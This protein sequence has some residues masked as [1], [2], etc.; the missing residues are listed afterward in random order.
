MLNSGPNKVTFW[1]YPINRNGLKASGRRDNPTRRH[2]SSLAAFFGVSPMYFF[3]DGT[4]RESRKSSP[5]RF[6]RRGRV[7]PLPQRHT[8]AVGHP[9]CLQFALVQALIWSLAVP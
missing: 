7:G 5:D 3:D 9:D 2:L 6:R 4:C 1:S 8:S